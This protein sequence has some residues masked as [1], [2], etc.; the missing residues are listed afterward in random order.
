MTEKTIT[1]EANGSFPFTFYIEKAVATETEKELIIEGVASTTNIDHDNERMSKEALDAMVNII[2]TTG[3]PLRVE[4]SKSENAVIGD[5]FKGWVDDRQQLH[6]QA[7]LD[8]SHPVSPILHHSMKELG[9][10][11]GFSVGG[12]VKRAMRE[13]SEA[14]GKI[15]KT[16]YDVEL[17]EVSVTPRPANYDSWAVAKSMAKDEVEAE[18]MRGTYHDTFLFE[19]PQMDYLQVFAK[20]VSGT[21]VSW[22][23]VEG[24]ISKNNKSDMTT[25]T[26]EKKEKATKEDEETTK[27][28]SR[29]EF[30]VVVKG[31]ETLTKAMEAMA[32][33]FSKDGLY[34][35]PKDQNAPAKEKPE[36]ESP[37]AKTA[38]DGTDTEG[39]R[40]KDMG[41][42]PHDQDAPAKDKPEDESPAAKTSDKDETKEKASDKKDETD[43]YE[44]KTVER[45]ISSLQD[46]TKR[47]QGVKKD[48]SEMTEE[49]KKKAADSTDETKEK[50]TDKEDET[51]KGMH[52]M[53]VFVATVTK[54]IEAMADRL[55][56]HG[57]NLIGFEKQQV[58]RIVNDPAMQ[59]EIQ[60]M[61]KIPG[62]KKS[63]VMGTPFMIAKSGKRFAL[64][65]QEVGV[66]T[67][68]K[69][70]TDANG[71]KPS[72]KDVYNADFSSVRESQRGE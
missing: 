44:M 52:P 5:V 68:E 23:R 2:N 41:S 71:K 59:V 29:A 40:E 54:T 6:I 4:H 64:T 35:G 30:R 57:M 36:D 27:G 8:K 21:D 60:K 34:T 72:F 46:L 38:A 18:A 20:S 48:S 50:A 26:D 49:E 25:E 1:L 61:L 67:I 37:A 19:N 11:M 32:M 51:E 66:P 15:V 45:S 58:E 13:F 43:T 7:R 9:K 39:T 10:K 63:V 70:R 3:V 16:F 56:K 17:K 31:I 24:S 33:S 22:N 47:I 42:K 69:S 53:D 65:A 55:E 14:K 12:L 28:V 62:A